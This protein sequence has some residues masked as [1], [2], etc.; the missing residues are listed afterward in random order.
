MEIICPRELNF[1]KVIVAQK[2]VKTLK[3]SKGNGI[4]VLEITTNIPNSSKNVQASINPKYI[5]SNS[6]SSTLITVEVVW[7][8]TGKNEF[9]LNIKSSSNSFDVRLYATVIYPTTSIIISDNIIENDVGLVYLGSSFVS[10]SREKIVFV[11]NNSTEDNCY[12]IMTE[13]Q[14]DKNV[15]SLGQLQQKNVFFKRYHVQPTNFQLKP[16]E[17]QAISVRYCPLDGVDHENSNPRLCLKVMSTA[18]NPFNRL[19]TIDQNGNLQDFIMSIEKSRAPSILVEGYLCHNTITLSFNEKFKIINNYESLKFIDN[20][21]KFN[22]YGFEVEFKHIAATSL[23]VTIRLLK[24]QMASMR[25]ETITLRPNENQKLDVRLHT[26]IK[27]QKII[28]FELL[29]KSTV[30]GVTTTVIFDTK[31]LKLSKTNYTISEVIDRKCIPL[32]DL[33][34]IKNNQCDRNNLVY[35]KSNQFSHFKIKFNKALVNFGKV[36]QKSLGKL[37]INSEHMTTI[38]IINENEVATNVRWNS[39]YSWLTVFPSNAQILANSEYKFEITFNENKAGDYI[40]LLECI[41]KENLVKRITVIASVIQNDVLTVTPQTV[42]FS[43]VKKGEEQTTSEWRFINVT[44]TSNTEVEFKW[45]AANTLNGDGYPDRRIFFGHPIRGVIPGKVTV[46]FLIS[47]DPDELFKAQVGPFHRTLE[48]WYGDEKKLLVHCTY[49]PNRNIRFSDCNTY[50]LTLTDSSV[51]WFSCGHLTLTNKTADNVRIDVVSPVF[52]PLIKVTPSTVKVRPM[53][54]TPIDIVSTL[55]KK[56]VLSFAVEININGGKK[57]QTIPFLVNGIIPKVLLTPQKFQIN[58]C[59]FARHVVRFALTNKSSAEITVTFDQCIDFKCKN[60]EVCIYP[61]KDYQWKDSQVIKNIAIRPNCIKWLRMTFKVFK[62]DA[63]NKVELNIPIVVNKLLSDNI[64]KTTIDKPIQMNTQCLNCIFSSNK[65][66]L[67]V[68][69]SRVIFRSLETNSSSTKGE[70]DRIL[71]VENLSDSSVSFSV[72]KDPS[73]APFYLI[74][75]SGGISTVKANAVTFFRIRF[76]TNTYGV[77]KCAL[78]IK[79]TNQPYEYTVEVYGDTFEWPRFSTDL[80]HVHFIAVPVGVQNNRRIR[81]QCS[82]LILKKANIKVLGNVHN[83]VSASFVDNKSEFINNSMSHIDIS[84]RSDNRP[85]SFKGTVIVTSER[86]KSAVI[87]V[88]ATC[89]ATET[90]MLASY[91]MQTRNYEILQPNSSI[92]H[93]EVCLK[94]SKTNLSFIYNYCVQSNAVFDISNY[95]YA[96]DFSCYINSNWMI[97]LKFLEKFL[98]G[99]VFGSQIRPILGNSLMGFEQILEP[100]A[101]QLIS[102]AHQIYSQKKFSF[103]KCLISLEINCDRL[104][105]LG[106][107]LVESWST[108]KTQCYITK[109]LMFYNAVIGYLRNNGAQ[110]EHIPIEI[111]LTYEEFIS[112]AKNKLGFADEESYELKP[113]S[114]MITR[115]DYEQ[116]SKRAWLD[117]YLCILDSIYIKKKIHNIP[118]ENNGKVCNKS[119]LNSPQNNSENEDNFCTNLNVYNEIDIMLINWI[120][121]ALNSHITSLKVSNLILYEKYCDKKIVDIIEDLHDCTILAM[122]I[123]YYRSGTSHH[124]LDD[125]IYDPKTEVEIYHNAITL[126]LALNIIHLS[127]SVNP[128]DLLGRNS[129]ILKLIL[130]ELYVTL[131]RET[132]VKTMIF[133]CQFTSC[134]TK[135]ISYQEMLAFLKPSKYFVKIEK[136]NKEGF[137]I[138][139]SIIDLSGNACN[140]HKLTIKYTATFAQDVTATLVFVKTSIFNKRSIKVISLKGQPYALDKAIINIQFFAKSLEFTK[141]EFQV[142]SPYKKIKIPFDVHVLHKKPKLNE[143]QALCNSKTIDVNHKKCMVFFYLSEYRVSFLSQNKAYITLNCVNFN[144]KPTTYWIWFHNI[145]YGEFFIKVTQ[146]NVDDFCVISNIISDISITNTDLWENIDRVL[147]MNLIRIYYKQCKKMIMSNEVKWSSSGLNLLKIFDPIYNE[148]PYKTNL[149][150]ISPLVKN[151]AFSLINGN[152]PSKW[153]LEK[154]MKR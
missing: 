105:K 90:L 7:F 27:F 86:C 129:A 79:P 8:K 41:T 32:I 38:S 117:V 97:N 10:V 107:S 17:T 144:M 142:I 149:T 46:R 40:G 128:L 73:D 60:I 153:H 96:T 80:T 93:Y 148:I 21:Y 106:Q 100:I 58:G 122:V 45:K 78:F 26:E 43:S 99:R 33:P 139:Q 12:L 140:D 52:S 101:V 154:K 44:N 141:Q 145:T 49:Y 55:T 151:K 95:I 109:L 34:S 56:G 121:T 87:Y 123:I 98:F 84:F 42:N 4:D 113:L 50:P 18:D 23:P 62:V 57:T 3:I 61:D 71:I 16:F 147:E 51:G 70:E 53:S 2:V 137:S 63:E 59:L 94:N 75:E 29:T 126:A 143:I 118:I 31:S 136:N 20:L 120:N 67:M 5:T 68:K 134:L 104:L 14:T 64:S 1:D 37:K 116:M 112:F 152:H 25:P 103:I 54:A 35:H 47:F 30:K 39:N 133:K 108:P 83:L 132:V 131:P 146:V 124:G 77:Y 135:S 150:I 15:L 36:T 13:N 24:G 28:S 127:F 130:F 74:G 6:R 69:P 81:V 66:S 85:C 92:S 89:T 138:G 65:S 102:G 88:T 11:K 125:I 119:P 111:L 82:S 115:Q 22:L 72:I 19:H 48:L 110:V 91:F 76:S 114:G 9:Y